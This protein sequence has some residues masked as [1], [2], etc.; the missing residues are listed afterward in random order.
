MAERTRTSTPL[1][2]RAVRH[3]LRL[4]AL[5]TLTGGVAGMGSFMYIKE[6]FLPWGVSATWALVLVGLG[7]AYTH[8]LAE[9]LAESISLSLVAVV[10]GFAVHVGAWIAPLWIL[11]YPPGAR[12]LILRQM[13]GRAVTSGI[14]AY[15]MTFYGSYFGAVLVGGYLEP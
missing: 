15:V 8:L 1:V 12:D 13:V 10:V 7:G 11:S 5:A 6:Q 3:R 2:G 14:L 9:D 4:L